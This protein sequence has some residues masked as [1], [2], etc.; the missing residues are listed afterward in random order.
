MGKTMKYCNSAGLNYYSGRL[1]TIATLIALCIT[2]TVNATTIN[3]GTT[4]TV[5]GVGALPQW[6]MTDSL[7]VNGTLNILNGGL[8]SNNDSRIGDSVGS[9][10]TVEVTGPG[11]SW[12]S[13]S[14]ISVGYDGEGYLTI[15]DGATVSSTSLFNFNYIGDWI[16]PYISRHLLSLNPLLACCRRYS[17]GE[18]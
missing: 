9:I 18:R 11:S 5:D 17:R 14:G 12:S 8:V 16:C 7:L 10:G 15:S 3:A 6:N 13:T 1:T 4:I 2:D